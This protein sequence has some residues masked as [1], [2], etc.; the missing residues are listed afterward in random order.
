MAVKRYPV[1]PLCRIRCLSEMT[2][3]ALLFMAITGCTAVTHVTSEPPGAKV[4]FDGVLRGETPVTVAVPD[5]F[6]PSAYICRIEKPGY[7]TQERVFKEPIYNI[8]GA[9]SAVP[10]SIHFVLE[11]VTSHERRQPITE[12]GVH[13]GPNL[14]GNEIAPFSGQRWGVIVGVSQYEKRGVGGLADLRYAARDAR[15]VYESLAGATGAGWPKQNLRLLTDKDA[16]ERNVREAVLTFLKKAQKDD[17]VLIFFSGHGSPDP[18]RPKNN[19]FLC[20]DTDPDK[21]VTTGFPMW[22][23]DNAIERGIIEAQRVVVMADACHSGGF[24]P[25]GM[26]DL[27]LVSRNVSDGIQI[28]A[29]RAQCRVVTS[30]EPGELSQ[31]KADWGGGHG[32]FSYALIKGL[33]GAADSAQDKNSRGNGDGKI[34]LDELVHYLRRQVGDLTSN[35]QHVQDGGRLNV[36]ICDQ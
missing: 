14:V 34:D 18:T 8:T 22:E 28:L 26:K 13:A 24:A 35:A 6:G 5:T 15:A 17:L 29:K 3:F 36:V 19:Y 21:L 20:H 25:E 11:R 12:D 23:I 32:A 9:P 2:C 1:L 27:S 7:R 30:C 4:S 10:D 33:S 16:T 31:E